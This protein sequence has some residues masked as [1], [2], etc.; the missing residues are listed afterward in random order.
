LAVALCIPILHLAILHLDSQA[1]NMLIF[2]PLFEGAANNTYHTNFFIKQK[3]FIML[4]RHILWLLVLLTIGSINV[5]AQE[6]A[7]A[8]LNTAPVLDK[9]KVDHSYKPLTLKLNDDGSKYVRFLIWNQMWFRYTQNNP[10]TLDA[11]GKELVSTVDIGARRLRFLAY[12][13]ISPRFLILTHWG[14]NNQTF[15]T[16]GAPNSGPKKPQLFI[17]D[18]WNEFAVIPDKLHIGMGLHYWQGPSRM[19]S[20]STLNFMTLDA[21]IINWQNIELE[22]QFARQLGIYAKGQIGRLDYRIAANK[23]FTI[24]PSV[25]TLDSTKTTATEIAHHTWAPTGYFAW[26]FF[27]KESQKLP[28]TVGSYLGSKK[29]F[30]IGAGFYYHPKGTGQYDAT[31]DGK[32][33]TNDILHWSADLYYERPINKEKNTAFHLYSAFYGFDYGVNY[34]RNI[35]IMNLGGTADPN[36]I[37]YNGVGNAQ[38]TIGTGDVWYTQVGYLLPKMG[39][40]GQLMPYGTFT[41][42]KFDKLNVLLHNLTLV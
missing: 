3:K 11:D 6:K 14:I 33:S 13:Q 36:T 1:L 2:A 12:A 22:D 18:A 40:K 38:P 37:T 4:Q 31:A 32:H 9:P 5:Y 8:A 21:P 39:D 19:A 24:N 42:K 34:L 35:G 20:A 16:G 10:G 29:I 27:D 25:N 7:K 41:Y 15:A 17:H 30:N 28:F 23:P 26:Q